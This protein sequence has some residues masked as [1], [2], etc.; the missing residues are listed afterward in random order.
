[1][2]IMMKK[3]IVIRDNSGF[4]HVYSPSIS[5]E[6]AQKQIINDLAD[7]VFSGSIGKLILSALSAKKVSTKEM[8][9]IRETL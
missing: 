5:E 6:K 8:F 2:Q 7:R 1:M 9:K 4:Q 3:G